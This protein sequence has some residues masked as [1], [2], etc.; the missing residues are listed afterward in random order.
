MTT[1]GRSGR[2][3]TWRFSI[4]YRRFRVEQRT[5]MAARAG[6]MPD[7]DIGIG[8]LPQRAPFMAL[9]AAARLAR[10]TAQASRDPRLLAQ[11]VARRRL[12]AVRTVQ[13]QPTSK[14][15]VLRPKRFILAPKHVDLAFQRANQRFDLERKTHSTLESKFDRLV[16]QNPPRPTTFP[17]PVA[18][19]THPGLGVTPLTRK[20]PMY[21]ILHSV[22]E[23]FHGRCSSPATNTRGMW[24]ASG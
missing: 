6:L 4:F 21:R 3:K 5:A 23:D 17:P 12:G 20:T 18:F 22:S 7:N 16:A 2:S 24:S 1:S 19:R 10:A 13:S 11:T 15:G 8:R 9:L 14:L